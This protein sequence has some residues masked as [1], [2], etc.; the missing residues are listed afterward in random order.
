MIELVKATDIRPSAYNP[1]ETDPKRLEYIEL[2]LRKLG[3][4]LPLYIDS[5]GEILSGHQR[6]LVAVERLKS[7]YVPIE[8]VKP[9][10]EIDLNLR[11]G[12]N[13]LFNRA[14]NDFGFFDTPRTV[15]DELHRS[16]ILDEVIVLPDIPVGSDNFF[17]CVHN[18]E[19]LPI[20]PFLK[21]ND[22]S[23]AQDSRN[24]AKSLLKFGVLM[25]IIAKHDCSVINGIGRLMLQAE[26]NSE[27]IDVI[28][29]SDD[30]AWIIHYLINRLSMEFSLHERYA[31]VL[32]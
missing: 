32:R 30:R 8:I 19:A 10:K 14:T 26:N 1:R 25:P 4:L 7:E 15:T 13:I 31:D 9:E 18:R 27:S 23:N 24:L 22:F 2:S 12:L 6:Q 16:G 17:P 5:A 3:F 21:V 20:M 28:T 11:K 29:V